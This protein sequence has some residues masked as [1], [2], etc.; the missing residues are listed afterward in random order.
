MKNLIDKVKEFNKAFNIYKADEVNRNLPDLLRY[1]L[2]K[3]ETLEYYESQNLEQ[4]AD[5][6]GDSLY[7][8]IGT[9][10]YHGLEDKII[11][12]F[13]E[14]QDSNMSKLDDNGKPII[15]GENGFFDVNKPLGKVLKSNNFVEPN[16]SKIL[17]K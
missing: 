11:D 13:N 2:M 17:N 16:L 5:A 10:I 6:L 8:L 7:V 15:N 1:N 12:I 4:I 3:E 9:I 14:I